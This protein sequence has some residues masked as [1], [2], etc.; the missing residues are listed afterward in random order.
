MAILY[1]VDSA[2]AHVAGVDLGGTKIRASVANVYGELI[3]EGEVATDRR[4]GGHVVRQI[5]RLV[6]MVARRSDVDPDSLIAVAIATPGVVDPETKAINLSPNIARWEGAEP[7]RGLCEALKTTVILD[8]DVNLAA[9]GEKWHGL[10]RDVTDY[11]FVAVGTGI[12]MGI[13]LDDQLIR[14]ATG[15]AGEIGYMPLADDPFDPSYRLRGPLENQVS[16][17]DFLRSARAVFGITDARSPE[18][19]VALA[20]GGDPRAVAA[21]EAEGRLI[22][23]AIAAV[24]SVLD[25]Q[26]VVLGGGLGSAQPLLEPIRITARRLLPRTPR[27]EHSALGSKAA[28]HGAVAEALAAARNQL[29]RRRRG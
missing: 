22:G 20:T 23:T 3:A 8:N 4:G 5:R 15:A 6:E 28:L 24:A 7:Y 26:L 29:F 16:G 13:V 25:P 21:I 19:I 11:V 12:G 10:A 1:S 2:V 27:I 18:D 17:P 9:I 14:G